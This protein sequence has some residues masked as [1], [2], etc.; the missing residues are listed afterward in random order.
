MKSKID[1]TEKVKNKDRRFGS[2]AEYFPV[3][4]HTEI[5]DQK[6]ALFTA[7]QIRVAVDRAKENPEDLPRKSWLAWIFG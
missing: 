3:M 5:G 2:A 1:L 4:V 7:D 6:E